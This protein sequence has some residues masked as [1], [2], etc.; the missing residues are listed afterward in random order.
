M[1]FYFVNTCYACPEQYDVYRDNGKACGY[2]RLR[3]GTLYANY[4][5][6]NGFTIYEKSFSDNHKGSFESED[7]RQKY[8]SKIAI[9][10]KNTILKGL[11][12]EVVKDGDVTFEVLTDI[13]QLEERLSNA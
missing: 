9:K 1:K 6:I 2:A 10:Y 12:D 8:L 4:P 7:E 13:S 5:G 11:V 3:W